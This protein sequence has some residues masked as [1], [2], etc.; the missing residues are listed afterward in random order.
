MWLENEI[1][2]YDN[3]DNDGCNCGYGREAVSGV[4]R[5]RWLLIEHGVG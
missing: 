4:G 3:G 5:L 1:L 2:D